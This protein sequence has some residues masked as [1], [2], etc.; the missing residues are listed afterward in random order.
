MKIIPITLLFLILTSCIKSQTIE[1]ESFTDFNNKFHSDSIFQMSR[2][3]FPINGKLYKKDI[4]ENWN[5]NN[6]TMLG[7]PVGE[8]LFKQFKQETIT[9]D[10]SVE[11]KISYAKIGFYYYVKFEL[12]KNKWYLVK[13]EKTEL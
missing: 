12:I 10:D 7:K 1:S 3:K 2:I 11:E 13:L 6:W 9:R 8:Y 5:M 4:E